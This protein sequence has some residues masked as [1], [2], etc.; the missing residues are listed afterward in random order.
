MIRRLAALLIASSALAVPA[1][2]AAAQGGGKDDFVGLY[3][4]QGVHETASGLEL[5]EDGRFEWFVS[6]GAVDQFAVGRWS[7][8]RE[9]IVLVADKSDPAGEWFAYDRAFPWSADA[10][11]A[12]RQT[13]YDDRRVQAEA[14]CPFMNAT[15]ATMMA[16]P[17]PPL[18][19]AAGGDV[20]VVPPPPALPAEPVSPVDAALSAYEKLAS[21]AIA[22]RGDADD[23]PEDAEAQRRAEAAEAAAQLALDRYAAALKTEATRLLSALDAVETDYEAAA[24]AAMAA[25]VAARKAPDDALLRQLAEAAMNEARAM[26]SAYEGLLRDVAEMHRA[27][28]VPL[29][30]RAPPD[31][32]P[33]CWLP[34]PPDAADAPSERSARSAGPGQG[35]G[36]IVGDP[37]AGMR[38][39]GIRVEFEFSDGHREQRVTDRGGRALLRARAGAELRRVILRN[40]EEDVR[41]GRPAVEE[42]LEIDPAAGDVFVIRLDSRRMA[43]QAFERMELRIDDEA[44]IPAWPERGE[45]GRYVRQ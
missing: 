18:E 45:R 8:E 26:K 41:A 4:L 25:H 13:E 20:S 16:T 3:F 15:E 11:R 17:A 9:R 24:R 42:A 7:R 6:Y 14:N 23:A 32:P 2:P 28:E 21:Q 44:L 40:G 19:I 31:L 30:E 22:A 29:P 27:A 34:N 33:A 37:E 43:P 5:R 39:S 12:L 1:S 10:E 38:F 35:L 36:V